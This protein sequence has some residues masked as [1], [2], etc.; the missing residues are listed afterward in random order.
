MSLL[1]SLLPPSDLRQLLAWQEI[2]V[3]EAH[4]MKVT[5]QPS[6]YHHVMTAMTNHVR[7]WQALPGRERR[8]RQNGRADVGFI[9]RIAI[10][11]TS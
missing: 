7:D 2:Q 8:E 11:P 9:Q 6:S 4:G 1:T 5:L 10:R 3:A